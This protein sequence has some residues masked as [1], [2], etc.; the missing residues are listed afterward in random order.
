RN[1]VDPL[2][3]V[4]VRNPGSRATGVAETIAEGG[5]TVS[6]RIGR[7]QALN[8]QRALNICLIGV[9]PGVEIVEL[10]PIESRIV[11][12]AWRQNPGVRQYALADNSRN[13]SRA[14]EESA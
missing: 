13:L 7:N 8:V 9:V 4:V 14:V 3:R 2:K 10:I 1:T 12:N 6:R 5:Q 11:D